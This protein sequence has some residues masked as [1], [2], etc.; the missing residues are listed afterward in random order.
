M[1]RNTPSHEICEA[2]LRALQQL[3]ANLNAD[4]E[5]IEQMTVEEL[6]A[7][8]WEMGLDPDKWPQHLPVRESGTSI[9]P[10][11]RSG[12]D[13]VV[14]DTADVSVGAL[15][16]KMA[17]A[18]AKR[19]NLRLLVVRDADGGGT[20]QPIDALLKDPQVLNLLR[21][22]CQRFE[23]RSFG[24]SYDPEDL[25]QDVLIQIWRY[26]DRLAEPGNILNL[27]DFKNWLFVVTRNQYLKRVRQNAK[28]R[29]RSDEQIEN[30]ELTVDDNYVRKYFLTHF[31]NFMEG[32]SDPRQLSI[33]FWLEGYSYREIASI[34]HG[35]NESCSHVTVRN[36]IMNAID[37]FRRTL[38][39]FDT[40]PARRRAV[41]AKLIQRHV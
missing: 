36:W 4:P 18:T 32:Y 15:S 33:R 17:A 2:A 10:A 25:Y 14:F 7:E 26:R 11:M 38:E 16:G 39:V 19:R 12:L 40:E 6:R 27:R 41:S 30:I 37:D 20:W 5:V 3:S 28:A 1:T 22:Y 29:N 9:E 35:R 8:M 24:R 34:L 23:F 21:R 13:N 31:L